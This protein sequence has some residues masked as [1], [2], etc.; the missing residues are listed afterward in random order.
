MPSQY[1]PA[2]TAKVIAMAET[3][4]APRQSFPVPISR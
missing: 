1:I 2:G 4:A 3:I